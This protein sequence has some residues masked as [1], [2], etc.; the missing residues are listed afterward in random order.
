M[1]YK[2][3]Y[4]KWLEEP[5]LLK[6]EKEQLKKMNEAE[7]EEAFYTDVDFGTGGIRGILGLGT[8]RINLYTIRKATLGL[9]NF[10]IKENE[11]NGVAI[12][13]DNRYFSYIFAKEAAM[14]LASQGIKSF[15]FDELR[16]TPMLSYAVR[17]FK[18]SAGIM[19]TASHNPKEYNGFKVYNKTGAQLNVLEATKVMEE[20]KNINSPFNIKTTDND[21]IK[22][23]KSD[24]DDLYLKEVES[25]SLLN[26][27]R[28]IK[29]VYSPLHGTGGTV[30]PKLLEKNG[31]DVN[32]LL[33]QMIVDPSFSNTK[34]SN[35]EDNDAYIESLKYGKE[36]NADI[37]FLTDPDADRL[38]VSVL[39]Q[40]KYH[41]LTGNQ[42]ASIMLYYILSVKE[43]PDG[44]VYTT[45]VTSNLIKDIAN[46]YHKKIGETLTGFKFIGEQA[47]LI[48]GKD[49]YIFGCEESYG[50]LVKDFVRD[51]DAVQ[52]VYLLSE[53]ANY[54][55]INNKTLIDYLNEIY[56]KFGFYA[57]KTVSLTFKG[58]KGLTK[59]K[60]IMK[61]FRENDLNLESFTISNKIDYING[62]V[63]PHNIILP[64]SDV[65]K[66]E[67]EDG[68]I[69]LRPS[70]TE[71]KLKI[72]YL[73]K[74]DALTKAYLK[75]E[76]IE[77]ELNKIINLV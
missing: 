34:S 19:I 43:Q 50:S 5:S 44:F 54:L 45:V 20:I 16:P 7:I 56:E 31:Y 24:F 68:F 71:P 33:K 38:G 35:P 6:E 63:N 69:V 51:K 77:K 55:K 73:V 22:I 58:I 39:H 67:S 2:L 52:A 36:I 76:N 75:L 4:K 61:H 66:Y 29:I 10:L 28:E 72:Y 23:I 37:I 70:G 59:I 17:H 25:I 13:Y 41:N 65:I 42:T 47:E 32:P 46:F 11:L 15:L 1:N 57:D 3:Q 9:A 60:D 64:S 12:S 26:L 21:L 74:D 18:A 40:G 62:H 14:V 48:K 30:I 49:N 8:N 27:K 53:I